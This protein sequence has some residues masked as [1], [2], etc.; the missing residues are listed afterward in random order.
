L[1]Q[2]R[3]EPRLLATSTT[4]VGDMFWVPTPEYRQNLEHRL[5]NTGGAYYDGLGENWQRIGAMS[6]LSSS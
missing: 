1:D 6:P 5:Y 3:V 2:V 4:L